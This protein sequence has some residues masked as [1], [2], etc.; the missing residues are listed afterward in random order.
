MALE[1]K[2]EG[3]VCEYAQKKGFL[4]PKINVIGERGWPDRLF[5][6]PEGWCVWI[7]FK[8]KGKPCTPIQ[9]YRQG[10]LAARGF[11]VFVC[12]DEKEGKELVDDLEAARLSE[13]SS[14]PV[15]KSG[16]RGV[17]LRP[18]FGED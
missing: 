1:K 16:K 4:T 8:Q 5:I 9:I 7:E 18:R 10:I 14:E 2:I 13:E 12:D 15:A 17:I 11:M 3:N 6:D